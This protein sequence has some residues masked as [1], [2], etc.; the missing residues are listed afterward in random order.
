V[1]ALIQNFNVFLRAKGARQTTPLSFDGSEGNYYTFQSIAWSPDAKHLV[2]YRV[3]PGYR[4]EVH[5]VESSPADQV[6]PKFSTR[7]Y[8]K[9]GDAVDI[10]QPVLF[11]IDAKTQIEIANALFPNPYSLSRPLWW[12]DSEVSLSITTSAAIRPTASSKSTRPTGGRARCSP[13]TPKH[14][15]ITAV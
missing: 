8:A 11:Q 14:S 15:S 6:Q 10:A 5:Y 12:K 1:E 3:H 2:A 9:P 4:R 13:R 7:V